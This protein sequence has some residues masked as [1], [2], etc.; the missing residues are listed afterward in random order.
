MIEARRS[1]DVFRVAGLSGDAPVKRLADL[2]ND[3]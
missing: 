1:I 2:A 3:D